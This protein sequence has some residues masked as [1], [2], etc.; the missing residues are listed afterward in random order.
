MARLPVKGD[1][2]VNQA[3]SAQEAAPF[4]DTVDLEIRHLEAGEV[5]FYEGEAGDH[6]YIIQD[7]LVE[8]SRRV[9]VAE[10][11]LATCGPGEIVGEMA[12]IDGKPRS[13][14]TRALRPTSIRVLPLG[15]FEAMLN[16]TDPAMRQLM[17]RFVQIIRRLTDST[18]RMTLGGS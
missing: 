4:K 13:A 1:H 6:A 12:L 14:T 17:M 10:I 11:F 15:H 7:G 18:V 2:S 16:G 5:L 8:I 9:G 3:T